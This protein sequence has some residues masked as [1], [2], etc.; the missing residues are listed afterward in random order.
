MLTKSVRGQNH[1]LYKSEKFI[2]EV[3]SY[4]Q[5]HDEDIQSESAF[6]QNI[7]W[8]LTSLNRLKTRSAPETLPR[9]ELPEM[10]EFKKSKNGRDDK[11]TIPVLVSL[12][13]TRLQVCAETHETV[14]TDTLHLFRHYGVL[15]LQR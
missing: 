6:S 14:Q 5:Y 8:H 7:C 11:K 12:T 4:L 9:P 2:Y 10:L 15:Q 3:Y 1:I 13:L